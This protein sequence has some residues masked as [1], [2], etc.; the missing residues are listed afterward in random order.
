[1]SKLIGHNWT[2]V[3]QF[4]DTFW[5]LFGQVS[6][7]ELGGFLAYTEGMIGYGV[8]AGLFTKKMM[9]FGQFMVKVSIL[10][11]FWLVNSCVELKCVNFFKHFFLFLSCHNMPGVIFTT[12][13]Q[14][15]TVFLD[16][17]LSSF[18]RDKKEW[19]EN[20][21]VLHHSKIGKV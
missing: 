1:M 7:F 4:L 10:G 21:V 13:N 15:R 17:F 12:A 8:Y 9:I 18:E 14:D 6:N 5:T 11:I 19:S 2:G 3:K 16:S 20:G